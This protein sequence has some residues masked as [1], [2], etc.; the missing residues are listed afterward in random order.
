MLQKDMLEQLFDKQI[1]LQTKLN[2]F[3]L[4]DEIARQEFININLLACLDELSE[5]MR[6]TAWKNPKYI[7]GG[8]KT[9]QEYNQKLFQ[10]EIVD[11]WHFVINLTLSSGMNAVDLYNGFIDKNKI[12]HQ[13]QKDGY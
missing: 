9:K 3:P 8:W 4:K 6:E 10:E 11:L 12:N 2:N 7:K 1:A 5:A 13:R